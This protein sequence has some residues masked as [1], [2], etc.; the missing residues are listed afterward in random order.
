M[1]NADNAWEHF[2]SSEDIYRYRLPPGQDDLLVPFNPAVLEK[3]ILRM[4]DRV[5]KDISPNLAWTCITTGVILKNA[6]NRAG[7]EHYATPY[8]FRRGSSNILHSKSTLH[9]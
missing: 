2:D 3:P 1:A 6:T 4:Y 8:H 9:L 5:A 7:F